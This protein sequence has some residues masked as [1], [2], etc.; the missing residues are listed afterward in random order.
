M[1][2]S[3]LARIRLEKRRRVD[4]ADVAD[5]RNI[6]LD[7]DDHSAGEEQVD[8]LNIPND[9]LVAG[10]EERHRSVNGLAV[11]NFVRAVPSAPTLEASVP[12]TT[13]NQT[14][15]RGSSIEDCS[16]SSGSKRDEE[17]NVVEDK[18][19]VPICA[20]FDERQHPEEALAQSLSNL[21]LARAGGQIEHSL[22][23]KKREKLLVDFSHSIKRWHA[24]QQQAN[25]TAQSNS[26]A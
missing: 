22:Y 24:E 16:S 8:M 3:E 12:G 9:S 14:V 23:L 15:N 13:D 11:E 2:P 7:S 4:F 18:D 26:G 20:T 1:R 10:N 21:D 19:R 25:T 17:A 6:Q 5:S